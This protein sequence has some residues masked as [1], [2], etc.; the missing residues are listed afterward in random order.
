MD[1]GN[2]KASLELAASFLPHFVEI[3]LTK[4]FPAPPREATRARLRALACTDLNQVEQ[5]LALARRLV[6]ETFVHDDWQN[7]MRADMDLLLVRFELGRLS[8]CLNLVDSL[9]RLFGGH[10]GLYNL[11]AADLYFMKGCILESKG[12]AL[13]AATWFSKS[14]EIRRKNLPSGHPVL[15]AAQQAC[16]HADAVLNRAS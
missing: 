2:P 15:H 9:I 7:R 13:G 10:S 11:G 3:H 12:C 1:T 6:N 5:E 14:L 8:D 4:S 16:E